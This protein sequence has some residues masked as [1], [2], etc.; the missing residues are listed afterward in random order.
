MR[1]GY[2]DTRDGQ[3]HY[4]FC[5]GAQGKPIIF[6]HQTASSSQSFEKLMGLLEKEYPVY[7]M[8]TPGFGQSFFP[9]E[10]PSTTYYGSI[11]L[12]AMGN[13][14]IG[15]C[16]LF[17]HHTGAAIAAE[18]AARAPD[19]IESLMMVGPLW[20]SPEHRRQRLEKV[21]DPMVIKPDG[22]HLM[23]VW[24]RVVRLDPDHP[25]DICHREAVNTLR[26]GERWHEG[27][28]AVYNQDSYAIY[29]KIRCPM[30]FLC[31]TNDPLF[32]VFK[33]ACEAFPEA[34]NAVLT[35]CGSYAI[36]NCAERIAAEIRN[37][38]NGLQGISE[39]QES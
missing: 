14:G 34:K 22:S 16:H 38:L 15:S 31:G 30:L 37:F 19:K 9:P 18:M 36:E 7:A 3:I 26:A 1:K 20:V 12:E 21:L 28:L 25:L 2:V 33:A 17:G 8:D 6:F 35:D 10:L 4:C 13:L 29:D 32:L 39:A 24:E 23:K 11:L 5:D 27:Y